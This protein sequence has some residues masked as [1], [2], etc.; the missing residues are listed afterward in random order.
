MNQVW[1]A[2][3]TFLDDLIYLGH[4]NLFVDWTKED[5]V[6]TKRDALLAGQSP[7]AVLSAEATNIP[8]HA[9]T[10]ISTDRNDEDIEIA[11]KS[12]SEEKEKTLRLASQEL[13]DEVFASMKQLFGD[14]FAEYEDQHSV[15]EA[16]YAPL[17]SLTITALITWLLAAAASTIRA[18]EDIDIEGRNAGLKA[19]FVW[20]L[21]FI[22][23]IGIYIV[24]GLLCVLFL[25]AVV[26]GIKEP[27]NM[28]LLQAG[29]YKP[30]S[31]LKL[32]G[33]YLILGVI[34]YFAAKALLI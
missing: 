15:A 6:A 10:R 18:A 5:E 1:C 24:G 34:W 3:D 32:A 29:P 31:K 8:L 22:G 26:V 16:T 28:L 23:P 13:R 25:M 21:D 30:Q 14:K 11:Y 7:G 19:L 33:K 12:G 4:E 27:P 9:I 20:L 17:M 2:D